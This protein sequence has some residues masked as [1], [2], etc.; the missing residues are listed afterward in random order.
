MVK[1]TRTFPT[2]K[3]QFCVLS[4][5][6]PW[7][8]LRSHMRESSSFIALSQVSSDKVCH[9]LPNQGHNTESGFR[10]IPQYLHCRFFNEY[11]DD[12]TNMTIRIMMMIIAGLL[13]P[14]QKLESILLL[15]T[16]HWKSAACLTDFTIL[17]L[18][19]NVIRKH[20]HRCRSPNSSP[21]EFRKKHWL[22]S[23]Y[24][25]LKFI[26]YSYCSHFLNLFHFCLLHFD[27]SLFTNSSLSLW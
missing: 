27:L 20:L 23:Y 21:L 16:R 13:I 14:F 4:A 25:F 10:F 5:K 22:F 3:S 17:E 7:E 15:L 18:S 2:V 12:Q 8:G 26:L 1:F 9:K 19:I 6:S 24:F 11:G